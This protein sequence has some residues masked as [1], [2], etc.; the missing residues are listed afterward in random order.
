MSI[1]KRLITP[2][3]EC[4]ARDIYSWIENIPISKPTRNFARDFSDC[5]LLA[6]IVH[7]FQPN[8][9]ELH[10]YS[11]TTSTGQKFRN[12]ETLNMKVLRRLGF[13][14]HQKDIEECVTIVPGALEK[15]LKKVKQALDNFRTSH[16]EN[17][18]SSRN[19]E[20]NR[21]VSRAQPIQQIQPK[22]S[23]VDD[24]AQ[25]VQD[26]SKEIIDLRKTVELLSLKNEK[27]EKLI[28]IKDKK[29]EILK[30][31]LSS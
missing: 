20:P 29:L 22:L 11:F 24:L 23:L 21:P 5:V 15:V 14:L 30:K 2:V 12:W 7:H 1:S 31:E 10:N 6:E 8:L 26:Q 25:Q 3:T 28:E 16:T 4:E 9:V 18:T 13:V 19:V 27:L 17:Q